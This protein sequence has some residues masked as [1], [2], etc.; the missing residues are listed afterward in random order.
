MFKN[1][2][3]KQIHSLYLN[4]LLRGIAFSLFGIFVPIYFLTLGYS[5]QTIFIYFVVHFISTFAFMFLGFKTAKKFSYKIVIISSIPAAILFVLFLQLLSVYAIPIYTIAFILGIQNGF[6]F[7]PFHAIFTKLSKDK[8]RGQ[9]YSIYEAFGQTAGLFGPLIGGIVA[10]F[11]G[12]QYLFYSVI[13]FFV[14][15][16]F[17][18]FKLKHIKAKEVSLKDSWKLYKKN[19]TWFIGLLAEAIREEIEGLIW[20]IFVYLILR[21]LISIGAIGFLITAGTIIFTLFLGKYYD[22]KSKYFFL[23][24][25]SV[26]YALVWILRIFIDNR[27]FLFGSSLIAGFL[28]VMITISINSIFYHKASKNINL[29]KF[30]MFGEFPYL[31][32][33][34]FTLGILIFIGSFEVAFTIAAIV[35]L[36]LAF[37]KFGIYKKHSY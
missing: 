6:Y 12:F 29:E 30:I 13:F 15:S 26:L 31:I 17:P 8:T 34:V 22:K 5:L 32:G 20:P 33:R 37:L 28:G 14:I 18:L 24:L 1:F 2:L 7:A 4:H 21:D 16:I 19:K 36:S 11:F 3:K 27:I 10:S 9:Q 35:S 23:R 25:G